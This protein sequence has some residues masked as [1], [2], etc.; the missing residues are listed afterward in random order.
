MIF[1]HTI[2][3]PYHL[4]NKHSK[5]NWMYFTALESCRTCDVGSARSLDFVSRHHPPH[6]TVP[7]RPNCSSAGNFGG[8][9]HRAA[10]DRTHTDDLEPE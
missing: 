8:Q 6:T 2:L 3:V 1:S 9:M 5:S 4:R 7:K 10:H